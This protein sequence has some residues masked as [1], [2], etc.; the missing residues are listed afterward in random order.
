[1]EI[2]EEIDIN[3]KKL[4]EE[5]KSQQYVSFDSCRIR[6][7]SYILLIFIAEHI[8]RGNKLFSSIFGIE[9]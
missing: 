3:L 9:K 2:R 8:L 7:M 1:M 4:Q 5:Y 6:K